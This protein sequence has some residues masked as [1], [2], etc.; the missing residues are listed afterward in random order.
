MQSIDWTIW[1][2]V[3]GV[4]FPYKKGGLLGFKTEICIDLILLLCLISD[5]YL[6]ASSFVQKPSILGIH[7]L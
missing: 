2:G 5:Y 1:F 6:Y 3:L 7:L 4:W